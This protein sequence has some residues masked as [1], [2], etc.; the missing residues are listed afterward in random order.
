M[1]K[2]HCPA[3]YARSINAGRKAAGIAQ[4]EAGATH[5]VVVVQKNGKRRVFAK[6]DGRSRFT[7]TEAN[8][9]MAQAQRMNPTLT[10]AVDAV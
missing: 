2:T 4:A 6:A 10:L 7:Q 9:W 8:E 3:S 5:S 1:T